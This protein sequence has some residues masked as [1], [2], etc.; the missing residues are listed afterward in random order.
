[1]NSYVLPLNADENPSD[2]G[3]NYIKDLRERWVAIDMEEDGTDFPVHPV[4]RVALDDVVYEVLLNY[5]IRVD[6]NNTDRLLVLKPILTKVECG[7]AYIASLKRRP[8]L[9][10]GEDSYMNRRNH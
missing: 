6:D 1:M 7:E 5:F 3:W 8:R 10:N 2:I 4:G 9:Y